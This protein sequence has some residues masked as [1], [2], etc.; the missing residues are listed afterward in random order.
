MIPSASNILLPFHVLLVDDNEHERFFFKSALSELSIS[1]HF[2]STDGEGLMDYL[3]ENT[4]GLPHI[5]FLDLN[6]PC[7]NGFECLDEL[8]ANEKFQGIPVIIY[9]NSFDNKVAD[10]LYENGAHYYFQ[11]TEPAELKK[12]LDYLL[13]IMMSGAFSRPQREK[14]VLHI[15]DKA[16]TSN[17]YERPNTIR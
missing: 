13:S 4:T 15:N 8:K 16:S 2:S 11:K 12:A 5:L 1:T 14:F 10:E 9:S 3:F 7:K 6:M 17:P